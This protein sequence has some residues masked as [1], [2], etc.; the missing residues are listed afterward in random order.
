MPSIG[1]VVLT[2]ADSTIAGG[3]GVLVGVAT[4]FGGTMSG[5]ENGVNPSW[6]FTD[7]SKEVTPILVTLAPGLVVY[8]APAGVT[9]ALSLVDGKTSLVKVKVTTDKGDLLGAPNVSAVKLAKIP[10]PRGGFH[11][12]LNATFKKAAPEGAVAVVVLGVTKKKSVGRS[13]ARVTGDL[14]QQVAGTSG[15]CDPGI[16]GEIVSKAGDKV[17]L[18]WVDA[19]GRLGKPSKPLAVSNAAP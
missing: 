19:S 4:E 9:G 1:S 12:Q 8:Q 5:A 6:R 2:A 10:E 11:L 7:G 14:Q 18:A 3:G 15:R 16:E 13:W 17:V